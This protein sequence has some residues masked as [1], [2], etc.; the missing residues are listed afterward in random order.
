MIYRKKIIIFVLAIIIII[1]GSFYIFKYLKNTSLEKNFNN[2]ISEIDLLI[3]SGYFSQADKMIFIAGKSAFTPLHYK[4]LLK[5]NLCL[6]GSVNLENVSQSAY[7]KYP[8]D[9][10]IL[11]AYI[12]VL[13]NNGKIEDAASILL[14]QDKQIVQDSL[15]IE[16]NIKNKSYNETSNLLYQ[17]IS[18]KNSLLYRKLYKLTNNRKFLLDAVLVHLETGNIQSADNILEEIVSDNL[19]YQKLQFFIKYDSGKFDSAL[20]I[21]DLFDC[22]FSIQ[23]I[24]LFRIDIQI[25]QEKYREAQIAISEFLDI[26]P[27]FSWI[28]YYNHI[29]LNLVSTNFKSKEI[30]DRSLKIY[31]ENRKLVLIILDYYLENNM[32]QDAIDILE[33]YI[34]NNQSDDELEIIL[35]ELKGNKNPEYT[36]NIVRNLV[37]QNPENIS[38]SRYLAW[39][40]FVNEDIL[41]LKHFLD[42]MQKEG[43][44]GWINFFGAL[45]SI[46]NRDYKLAMDEFKVSYDLKNQWETLYNLAVLS[47]YTN[48]YQDAIEYYQNAE[49]ILSDNNENMITKS[50]IRTALALLLYE[51]QDYEHS[52]REVRNALD[53]DIYNLRANLLLK[54]LESVSF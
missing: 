44:A 11:S 8:E 1:S 43:D 6:Q 36:V 46:K 24:Q 13:L 22:G 23:E 20:E 31:P 7:H 48:N 29:W 26:Y 47:E 27:R 4:R 3:D 12:Y 32:D 42:Q 2:N 16:A 51:I 15:F 45:I 9:E 30:I 17:G 14:N 49:N 50:V 19:E 28:P 34:N 52:Y 33:K 53:L 25:R 5:R 41:H 38:A 54:K 10:L 18:E 35:K 37:N 40:I 21:L 39:N